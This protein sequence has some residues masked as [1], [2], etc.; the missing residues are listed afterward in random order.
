MRNLTFILQLSAHALIGM[1]SLMLGYA[2]GTVFPYLFTIPVVLFSM[3]GS[4]RW[5]RLQFSP[6]V[7]NVCGLLAFGLA[8][9]GLFDGSVESRLLS[10]AHLLIAL[11]WIVLLQS[12]KDTQY[13]WLFA[14][15]V[16]QVSVGSILTSAIL[17]TRKISKS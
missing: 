9:S 7:A 10:G 1:A 15:A 11:T 8:A 4:N 17:C 13:W 14:L 2:E 3:F 6:L 12:K 5:P 16:L